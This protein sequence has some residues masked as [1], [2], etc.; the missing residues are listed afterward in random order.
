[1]REA[2]GAPL[3]PCDQTTYDLAV[4][5]AREASGSDFAAAWAAGQAMDVEEALTM[6]LVL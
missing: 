1:M 3:A 6:E 4:A 5:A 2:L